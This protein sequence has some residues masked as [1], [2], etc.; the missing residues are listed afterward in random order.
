MHK[1]FDL[2]L[3]NITLEY[4]YTYSYNV[5]RKQNNA[6]VQKDGNPLVPAQVATAPTQ[7]KTPHRRIS[8]PFFR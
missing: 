1:L 6:A 3:W 8:I 4:M 7:R 2:I 5:Y